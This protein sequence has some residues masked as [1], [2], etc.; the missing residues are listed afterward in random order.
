MS[1]GVLPCACLFIATEPCF[2]AVTPCQAGGTA[3]N[4]QKNGNNGIFLFHRDPN[5]EKE[6]PQQTP[7]CVDGPGKEEKA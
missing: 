6:S 7:L 4:K 2:W 1:S 5:M 3:S